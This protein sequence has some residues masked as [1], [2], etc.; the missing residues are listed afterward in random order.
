MTAEG[1]IAGLYATGE[2]SYYSNLSLKIWYD[3]A[4]PSVP[5]TDVDPEEPI[6]PDFVDIDATETPAALIG[7]NNQTSILLYI[8]GLI[9]ILTI[10][11]I[12]AFIVIRRRK[13]ISDATEVTPENS[14]T[15]SNTSIQ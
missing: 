2:F 3:L 11:G 4:P 5:D 13:Q 14:I 8:I 9:T 10:F 12:V 15:N 1:T 7:V 6:D